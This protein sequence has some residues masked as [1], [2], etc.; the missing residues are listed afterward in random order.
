MID[1]LFIEQGDGG[2]IL[3]YGGDIATDKGLFTAVYVSLFTGNTFFNQLL[4]V[5]ERYDT[6][7]IESLQQP[8]TLNA[9]R[10]IETKAVAN[11]AWLIND[12]GVATI[13]V[14]ASSAMVNTIEI[15][16]TLTEPDGSLNRYIFSWDSERSG[17]ARA[18]D[19]SNG[20][21]GLGE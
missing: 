19:V 4:S 1:I 15:E 7:F 13:D 11:L 8:I 17:L 21:Y 20:G 3:F 12:G 9:L 16:I 14:E 6:E 18:F 5:P 10:N 2:E